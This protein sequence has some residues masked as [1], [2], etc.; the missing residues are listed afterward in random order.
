MSIDIIQAKYDQ[1]DGVARRFGE[2][3]QAGRDLQAGIERSL[4]SLQDG[5]WHGRGAAAFFAEMNNQVTPALGRLSAALTDAQAVTIRIRAILQAAEEE[6]SRPFRGAP[7]AA[8][9]AGQSTAGQNASWWGGISEWIHG[10]LDVAGFVPGFGEIADG[11]NALIYLGE[12]RYV[13][14]GIS[15]AAMIP[16][17]GDVGKA[18][19][20]VVK[21]GKEVLE[22][23]AERAIK[24]GAE[25][26]AERVGREGAEDF[27]RFGDL[28]PKATY[29]RN[30]YEYATDEA[31]RVAR[32]GGDLRLDTSVRTPH[33]T[34]VGQIGLPGDEGGHLIGSR[35][36]GTPEGVNLVPQNM[37]LNRGAWKRMENDWATALGQNKPVKV[38]IRVL[39]PPGNSARPAVFEVQYW[40]DGQRRIKTFRNQPGG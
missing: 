16:I 18:G 13:E 8:V 38:D 31:G 14:A 24:E 26:A 40:I 22:E 21:G 7:V 19:K 30:G 28:A 2:Q 10:G 11:A 33:Q 5:G 17:L 34:E 29:V 32:V 3:A 35:F 39:Y 20:W 15:A 1:L 25:E 12:G 23:G 27:L 9:P 6:A 36:G 37:N 4:R